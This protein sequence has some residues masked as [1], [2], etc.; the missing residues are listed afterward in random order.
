MILVQSFDFDVDRM[1]SAHAPAA[2]TQMNDP[3]QQRFDP[4]SRSGSTGSSGR[5]KMT[6]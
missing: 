5:K 2:T 6:K 3:E 1:V 4:S